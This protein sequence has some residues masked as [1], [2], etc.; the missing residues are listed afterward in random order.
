MPIVKKIYQNFIRQYGKK[1]GESRYFAWEKANP[2]KYKKGLATARRKG[3]TIIKHAPKSK[4]K[5]RA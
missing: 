1:E 5:K 3:D 4:K 2:Q